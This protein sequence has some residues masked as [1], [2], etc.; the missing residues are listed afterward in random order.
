MRNV[1]KATGYKI[2]QGVLALLAFIL[3]IAAI[4]QIILVLGI[5]FAATGTATKFVQEK[6]NTGLQD[7]GY[8]LSFSKIFYNPIR[9]ITIYDLVAEDEIGPF[10][11]LD[12]FSLSISYLSLPLRD[13]KLAAHGG[14][15][16]LLRL[17]QSSKSDGDE[18]KQAM[19][20]FSL[21]D[22]YV[23]K[24]S[25]TLS[26]KKATLGEDIAG[27]PITLSP[28]LKSRI[29]LGE[30]ASFWF[31]V[32]PGLDE[33]SPGFY[34]PQDILVEGDFSPKNLFLDLKNAKLSQDDYALTAKGTGQFIQNG[35]IDFSIVAQHNSLEQLTSN[36]LEKFD[37]SLK[38]KGPYQ[39]PAIDFQGTFSPFSLKEKG[40]GDIDLLFAIKD[41]K[42]SREGLARISTEFQKKPIVLESDLLYEAPFLTFHSIKGKAPSVTISGNGVLS[43][44]TSV[45][46]GKMDVSADDVSL[47]RDLI[48]FDIEGKILAGA[49]F[50]SK[51]S[52]QSVDADISIQNGRYDTVTVKKANA[53]ASLASILVPWPQS[54]DIRAE[55]IKIG[56]IASLSDFS[57]LIAE[58]DNQSYKLSLKGKGTIPAAISFNGTAKLSNLSQAVPSAHDIDFKGLFGASSINLLGDF[59][60]DA[61]DLLITTKDFRGDDIPASLP[62]ALSDLYINS[63]AR[64]TGT[65]AEP[66]TKINAK[67]TGLGTEYYRDAS[68]TADIQHDGK[69]VQMNMSGDG[70][71]IQRLNADAQF[72]LFLSFIP[73]H[74]EINNNAPLTGAMAAD[75]DLAAVSGLFLPPT[76]S[77]AGKLSMN[78]TISGT[79]FAPAPSATL[80]LRETSFNDEANGI[81][82]DDLTANASVTKD[83]LNL[84]QLQATDGREGTLRGNGR[85][86]FDQSKDARIEVQMRKFHV[87]QTSMANG[88]VDADLSM[89]GSSSG[90][91]FTGKIDV[92]EMDILIP[93]TFQSRI[94]EL[95]IIERAKKSKAPFG[96]NI[97]LD[98]QINAS[99]QVFVRGWGLDAEFGG[100]VDISGNAAS[101][102]F[103]GSLSSKRGRYE[104]FGKRFTLEHANL[105]FQ[106]EI[107]PSPYL[108]IKA[109]TPGDDVT[110][111]ILLTGPVKSPS[112]EFSSTPALPRDEVLS[113]I[114][115]GKESSKISPFQAVQLAQTV[116]RFSGKGGGF[117]P[118][119]LLRST[120][121]LDDISIETDESGETNVGVG[122]YLTDR[123]YLEL[124]KGKAENSGA[125]VIQLEVTPSINI[126]SRVGQDA[127]TGGGVLWKHDY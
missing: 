64:I 127:Q 56:D 120:T 48:P 39:G 119:A 61:L 55:G 73:F 35:E 11:S 65:P 69:T 31:D 15:L 109:I 110:A 111:A 74:W 99:Q 2:G 114:L 104:E 71:G 80:S 122:K 21:P 83:G 115:F 19:Q 3:V 14:E 13:L 82:I 40:L 36:I 90:L 117:D 6:I 37:G 94:P 29:F 126:E 24:A 66:H 58:I 22:I 123:V 17:P 25:L 97:K 26:L 103:N 42:K 84:T 91:D 57:A 86:S 118:L 38:I 1:M 108:D 77:L 7:S 28:V 102:Q 5:N 43:T 98:I 62:E 95:N 50:K 23:Q 121:G 96:E 116:Q 18:L 30:N 88:I 72:P 112:I 9:G 33:I 92:A 47:Y 8:N 41:I 85:V 49:V 27:K 76:Q 105:R 53:K 107:P 81:E 60:P 51:N 59:T 52:Q 106:G 101:P 16:T 124:E 10:L 4:I 44:Q 67:F 63:T 87:P 54:A 32:K 79:V 113:R 20:P 125:A 46:D 12:R 70:K 100:E 34:A 78:G 93:E 89:K 75:I 45:F 68:L